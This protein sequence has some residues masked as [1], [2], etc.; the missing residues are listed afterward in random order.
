MSYMSNCQI[1]RDIV[2]Q[3][4][5]IIVH[6]KKILAVALNPLLLEAIAMK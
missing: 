2:G 3:N 1:I 5:G 6:K 4:R